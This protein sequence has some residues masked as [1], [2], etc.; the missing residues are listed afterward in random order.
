MAGEV[1]ADERAVKRPIVFGVG[2]RMHAD[3]TAAATNE[4]LERGFLRRIQHIARRR[5]KHDDLVLRER[6]V[7]KRGAVFGR[8][9]RKSARASL[10]SNGVNARWN[11]I[12][13]KA[14]GF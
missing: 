7:T 8:I 9:D 10:L 4:P 12:V 1:G 2:R 13:P 14:G 6:F 5:Q 11:R 3:K